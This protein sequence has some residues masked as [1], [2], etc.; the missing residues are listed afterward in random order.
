MLSSL[1][2]VVIQGPGIGVDGKKVLEV[3]RWLLFEK[4]LVVYL[5]VKNKVSSSSFKLNINY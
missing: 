5:L 1:F 3:K 4:Y 2:T